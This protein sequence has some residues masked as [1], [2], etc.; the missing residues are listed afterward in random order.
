MRRG[1]RNRRKMR[2]IRRGRKRMREITRRIKGRI[3]RRGKRTRKIKRIG[4]KQE[5]SIQVLTAASMKI[6][7]FWVVAPCNR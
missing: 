2:R 3:K 4:R 5:E 1:A 6:A 7:V